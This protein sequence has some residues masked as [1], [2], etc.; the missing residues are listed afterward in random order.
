M[1][2]VNEQDHGQTEAALAAV[3]AVLLAANLP[4]ANW[5]L[6]VTSSMGM[7]LRLYMLRCAADLADAA[8][9]TG[10]AQTELV[11]QTVSELLPDVEDHVASWLEQSAVDRAG[12]L[13]DHPEATGLPGADADDAAGIIG[14]S[15]ATYVREVTRETIAAR[16][17]ATRKIWNTMLDNRV[18]EA[19]RRMEGQWK[20]LGKPFKAPGGIPIRFPGDPLAPLDLIIGCRCSC[21]YVIGP[22]P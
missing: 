7:M 3:I 21:R 18:R 10:P 12:K 16:L 9:V 20:P 11:S 13:A 14:R 19:H 8:G 2:G 17:G 5:R 4:R 15:L 22:R 6:L 1:D